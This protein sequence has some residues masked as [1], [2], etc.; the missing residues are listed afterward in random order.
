MWKQ[1]SRA[2]VFQEPKDSVS[3]D[4]KRCKTVYSILVLGLTVFLFGF[5]TKDNPLI[6]EWECSVEATMEHMDTANLSD[7]EKQFYYTYFDSI[8][9]EVTQ[10]KMTS[11]TM[12]QKDSE[13]YEMVERKEDAV[14]VY[15]PEE[16]EQ[17]EFEL[18]GDNQIKWTMESDEGDL[19]HV[20]LERQ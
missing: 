5:M 13:I 11:E 2:E 10:D 14:V 16:D 4:S 19:M 18:I 17:D 12:T 20:V 6:G 9:L 8:S 3:V 7:M 15:Y 1:Q